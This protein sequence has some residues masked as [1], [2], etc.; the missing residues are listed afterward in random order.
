[1]QGDTVVAGH[2]VGGIES[3][4]S[5]IFFIN[6]GTQS[7]AATRI[8]RVLLVEVDATGIPEQ[9]EEQQLLSATFLSGGTHLQITLNN[10]AAGYVELN[11]LDT[12]G[13]LVKKLFA[14]RQPV[15]MLQ[16]TSNVHDLATG[17]YILELRTHDRHQAIRIDR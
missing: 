11:V 9:P 4:A 5:N 17:G 10:P 16:F 1:L 2:I 6:T 7:S 3:S 12:S 15:G 8:F 14:A 13:R